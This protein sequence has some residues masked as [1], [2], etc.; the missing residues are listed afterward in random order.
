MDRITQTTLE[1]KNSCG[2]R[3]ST[4]EI[5]YSA[6]GGGVEDLTGVIRS[7]SCHG[8]SGTQI[9]VACLVA[10]VVLILLPFKPR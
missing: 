8:R 10:S 7:M 3:K 1:Y 6:G 4:V 5:E 2:K 9:S